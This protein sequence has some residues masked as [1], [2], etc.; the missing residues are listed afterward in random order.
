MKRLISA[1]LGILVFAI[2]FYGVSYML[3]T[4]RQI[5]TL[6]TQV[7]TMYHTGVEHGRQ[8]ERAKAM[9][10]LNRYREQIAEVL[11]GYKR[12]EEPENGRTNL[13]AGEHDQ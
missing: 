12:C 8:E 1:S 9:E 2:V 4:N 5:D 7:V 13:T 10:Y 11:R 6:E 3:H